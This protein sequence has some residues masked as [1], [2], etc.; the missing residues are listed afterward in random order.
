MKIGIISTHSWPVLPISVRAHTGDF[1]YALL[2]QTL[3]EIGHEVT[4]FAPDGS[5][6]PPNGKQ[7]TMPCSQ[8]T[9]YPSPLDCEQEC[10]NKYSNI[11][12]QQ[13]IVHDFSITKCIA[14]NLYNEGYK[15]ITSTL[16]G[17]TWKNINYK[18]NIICQSQAQ[19]ERLL[20]GATDY[21]NAP[22]A[23]YFDSPSSIIIKD[24]HV[25]HD[26][27]DTDFYT[28]QEGIILLYS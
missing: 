10:Y 20:R 18:N 8:G 24:A 25:V 13:D 14:E 27:I 17:G 23:T 11:L 9:G 5:Y 22:P 6:I 1:F 2:A 4:F 12:K 19:R 15:N 21:E 26:G 3:D 16:M 28:L 7:L